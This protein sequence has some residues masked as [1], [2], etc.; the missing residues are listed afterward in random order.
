MSQQVQL[1][2]TP[3][4]AASPSIYLDLAAKSI[5]INR[6]QIANSR[7]I[8]RSIDARKPNIKVNLTLELFIDDEKEP[9]KIDFKWDDVSTKQEVII[10]GSGPSGLFAALRLI[11]NGLKP[12][13]IERGKDVSARKRDIAALNRNLGVNVDSNYCFGEGGAGTYSDGKLFTRSKKRGNHRRAL[14]I[15]HYHGANERILYDAH[16]HIG[17]DKLPIVISA[18]RETII[19]AGGKFM[20]E[21]RVVDL[22]IKNN[23]IE[24]VIDQNGDR[25]EAAATILATGH[26]A[27]DIYELL[28]KKCI[29]LEVKNFAMGVRVEHPQ[30]IIDSIQYHKAKDDYLPAASYSLVTQV[31]ERGVYSFCMCPGGFIVPSQTDINQSVVNG[32]SPSGRNSFFAN[33]GIVTEVR[34][35]DYA[36]LIPQHGVLA[37]LEFQKQFEQIAYENG[38]GASIVPGQR[39]QDFVENKLSKTLPKTSYHAGAQPSNMNEW[40]PGFISYSLREGFKA[41][42][43]KMK[44]FLTNE[45]MILG[46]ESRTSSPLRI[47]RDK[48]TLSHP[49]IQGLYPA[50]EGAGYAGGIISS[51]VDGERVADAI[52]EYLKNGTK[53]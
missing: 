52:V 14:E 18:I 44:G 43:T 35:S 40:M 26:S 11:E 3:K 9:D 2:L 21:N 10:V 30:R 41:F 42:N 37:G 20:L 48:D 34:E 12:I 23:K 19:K 1:Q 27:R 24:G 47:P 16:P 15:F 29:E 36:H 31:R 33:S 46:V 32:M 39:V 5:G 50:G 6:E 45:A 53:N 22:I 8:K 28:A 13:V 17:T 38:G 4:E 51:A 7:I 49:Q 25:I